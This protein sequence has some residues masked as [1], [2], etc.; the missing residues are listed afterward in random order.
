MIYIPVEL[1]DRNFDTFLV[2]REYGNGRKI[3]KL[4]NV[5]W[6][7]RHTACEELGHWFNYNELCAKKVG[8]IDGKCPEK[9]SPPPPNP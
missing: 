8:D 3:A 4:E 7:T 6:R 1:D 9:D 5:K 2:R